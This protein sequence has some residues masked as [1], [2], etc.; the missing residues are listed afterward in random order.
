MRC[1]LGVGG[2]PTAEDVC[3]HNASSSPPRGVAANCTVLRTAIYIMQPL[4]D[5]KI[6]QQLLLS[7]G[8]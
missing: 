5:L 1:T 4:R 6:L 2:S 3:E 7:F 8:I